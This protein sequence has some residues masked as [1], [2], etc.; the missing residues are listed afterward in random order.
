MLA[1]SNEHQTQEKSTRRSEVASAIQLVADLR[2][3]NPRTCDYF[4]CWRRP[5][6]DSNQPPHELGRIPLESR[7]AAPHSIVA[8]CDAIAATIM[9]KTRNPSDRLGVDLLR[10]RCVFSEVGFTHE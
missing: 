1:S 7:Q 6:A 9:D 8:T 4:A 2:F 3:L 10:A 5:K